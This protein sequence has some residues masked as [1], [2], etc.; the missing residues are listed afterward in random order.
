MYK[1]A[2]SFSAIAKQHNIVLE[3]CSEQIELGQ[4]GIN[5]GACINQQDIENII[6]SEIRAKKQSGL[7]KSCKC[8]ESIDIGAYDSCLHGCLYCYAN[9]GENKV[10]L[11]MKKHNVNSP[12]LIGDCDREIIT[13]KKG[14]SLK[15]NQ[16]NIFL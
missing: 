4:L 16:I 7:R 8:I 15:N 13:L 14:K 1:I 11:N 10:L 9:M 12:L 6:G 5:H 3:T 2:E